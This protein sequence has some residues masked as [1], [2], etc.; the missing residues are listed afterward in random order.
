MILTRYF[1]AFPIVL[2]VGCAT[3]PAYQDVGAPPADRAYVVVYRAPTFASG[4]WAANFW[5]DGTRF[6]E[7]YV[8]GYTVVSIQPGTHKLHFNNK[9]AMPTNSVTFEAKAGQRLFF[10]YST[11]VGTIIPAGPGFLAINNAYLQLVAHD[12]AP[13][14]LVDYKLTQAHPSAID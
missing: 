1:L 9:E 13:S 7:L 14:E 11:S 5:L 3:G 8:K 10:R 4:A 6:A 12:N 2:L